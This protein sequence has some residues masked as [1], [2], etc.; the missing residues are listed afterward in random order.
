MQTI[1]ILQDDSMS[2]I[3]ISMSCVIPESFDM[4][5]NYAILMKRGTILKLDK[6]M[7]IHN[8]YFF[9][10]FIDRCSYEYGVVTIT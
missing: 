10:F 2:K 8:S 6:C 4:P 1:I 9:C 7:Y 3:D 5:L